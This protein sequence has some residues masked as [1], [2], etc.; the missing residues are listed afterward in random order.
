MASVSEMYQDVEE[1][2]RFTGCGLYEKE[3]HLSQPSLKANS[4][5]VALLSGLCKGLVSVWC[6]WAYIVLLM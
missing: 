1:Y 4:S 5:L 2:K 6:E 3:R